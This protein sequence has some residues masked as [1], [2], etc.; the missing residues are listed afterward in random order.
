MSNSNLTEDYGEEGTFPV[1]LSDY[2]TASSVDSGGDG[3]S[4]RG[5]AAVL[6]EAL[7][8]D[9][10]RNAQSNTVFSYNLDPGVGHQPYTSGHVHYH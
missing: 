7:P 8:F 4:C 9:R 2:Q 3:G 6:R 5:G 1:S 10:I